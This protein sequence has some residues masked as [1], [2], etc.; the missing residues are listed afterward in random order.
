M[1]TIKIVEKVMKYVMK[2][3]IKRL[4]LCQRRCFGVFIDNLE[5]I[6]R[7]FLVFTVDFEQFDAC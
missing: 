5:H 3:T 2:L 6:S 4:E 7:L 1:P